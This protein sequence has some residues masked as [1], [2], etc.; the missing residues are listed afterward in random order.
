MLDSDLQ[1]GFV[2]AEVAGIRVSC[3]YG[4]VQQPL[5]ELYDG[6]HREIQGALD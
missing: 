2:L 6:D 5:L 4:I 3:P 1:P